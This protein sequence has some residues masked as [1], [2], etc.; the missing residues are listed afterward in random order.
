MSQVLLNYPKQAAFGRPLPKTKIY[1]HSGASAA[2]RE[3]FVRQVEQIVWQYKLAPETVNL[4]AVQSVLEIQVFSITLKIPELNQ[5]ALRCIDKV[6]QHPIIFELVHE[7]KIQVVAAY[8]RIKTGVAE[9]SSAQPEIS[10]YFESEWLPIDSPRVA[11]P[12]ALNMGSLYEQILHRLIPLAAREQ[13][14]LSELVS[15][16]GRANALRREITKTQSKLDKEKQ[17]NRKVEIN[18][19][20]R[21]LNAEIERLIQ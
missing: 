16:V 20:L 1:E 3:L 11:M 19:Q 2:M 13:E 14:S 21:G 9:G 15:R 7:G 17:F 5:D 12:L 10:D 18:A 4:P 8:K 6:V